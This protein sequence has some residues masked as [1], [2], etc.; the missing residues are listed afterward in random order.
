MINKF[1]HSLIRATKICDNNLW[2]SRA[3]C[4]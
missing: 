1:I 3:R 2:I 4:D